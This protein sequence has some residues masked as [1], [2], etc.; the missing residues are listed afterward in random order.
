[1]P[2]AGRMKLNTFLILIGTSVAVCGSG[3]FIGSSVL[4]IS[5]FSVARVE[6]PPPSTSSSSAPQQVTSSSS[7]AAGQSVDSVVLSWMGR[8]LGTDKKKDV[9]PGSPFKVNLYQDAGHSTVNRAKVDLDR[10]DKWDQK[11]TFDGATATRET[12]PSDDENYTVTD[13]WNGSSWSRQGGSAASSSAPSSSAGT[14][15][16]APAGRPVDQFILGQ[17]G[18]DLGSDKIK[19]ATKGQTYKV[20]LY[21]DAGHSTVNRA[22]VDLD[23]D[24]KWDEKWTIDGQTITRETAPSDDENYTVTH[25]WTGSGWQ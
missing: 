6:A 13:T 19:D 3:A 7:A 24:D 9:Q 16:A 22:K 18:R 12:A 5:L 10:D 20:N 4:G 25:T 8:D 21:Q 14:A 17:L 2:L 1:M 11:W 15:A 23:R